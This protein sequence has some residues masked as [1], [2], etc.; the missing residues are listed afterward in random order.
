MTTTTK[1]REM[2]GVTYVWFPCGRCGGDGHYGGTV[3]G[4]KCFG[5]L[6]TNGR[7]TGGEWITEAEAKARKAAAKRRK[8]SRDAREAKRLA[9]FS[10]RTDT[11]IAELAAVGFTQAGEIMRTSTDPRESHAAQSAIFAVRDHGWDPAD[12]YAEWQQQTNK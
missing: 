12:A 7:P 6:D 8:A 3:Q 10:A 1:T 11:A 4:G 2:N 5:C 9:E